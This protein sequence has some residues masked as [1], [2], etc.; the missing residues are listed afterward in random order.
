MKDFGAKGDGV[1]DDTIAINKAISA[2][3]RCAPGLLSAG[4]CVSS[5]TTP[6]LVYFPN[7]TYLVTNPIIDS[8]YTQIIGNPIAGCLPTIKAASSFAARWVI[9]AD[10]YQAGGVLSYGATNVFWRQIRNFIIDLTAIPSTLQVAGIHWPTAQATSLQNIIIQM[11]K[12]TSTQ[13]QG[14]FIE[15]GSGGFL[16]DLVFNGGAQGLVVDNQ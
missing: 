8:Y 9:D 14:V 16:T 12:A 2:G 5:S 15:S 11:S 6:A 1:T 7:G 10:V 4:S 13:H 3:N